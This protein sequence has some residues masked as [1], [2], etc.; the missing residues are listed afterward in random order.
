VRPRGQDE[1]DPA[2]AVAR[3][4]GPA[5]RPGAAPRTRS[6]RDTS[7]RRPRMRAR[8]AR[9]THSLAALEDK[10]GDRKGS[11]VWVA[12]RSAARGHQGQKDARGHAPTPPRSSTHR[13]LTC[14]LLGTSHLDLFESVG[15]T[16]RAAGERTRT[17]RR[18]YRKT[19]RDARARAIGLNTRGIIKSCAPKAKAKKK[20]SIQRQVS[21]TDRWEFM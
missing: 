7:R 11:E 16:G 17:S 1:N 2:T 14:C 5:P 13:A 15:S 3:R 9:S 21:L 4:S 18:S 19:R 8:A 6:T 12:N 20:L 10:R